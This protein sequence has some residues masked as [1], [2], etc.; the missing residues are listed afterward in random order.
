MADPSTTRELTL[1]ILSALVL[2][3]LAVGIAYI[4]G[5]LF[6]LFWAA[7]ALGVFWEWASLVAREDRRAV[8]MTGGAAIVLASGLAGSGRIMGSV[9]V[10]AMGALA[11]AGLAG[12][13]ERFW[14][15]AGLPYAGAIGIAPIVLRSESEFG[16]IAIILLFAVVWATDIAAYVFGRLIGGP[17]LMPR[18]SPH[19]TWSGAIA[20]TLTAVAAAL[21]VAKAAA[22]PEFFAIGAVAIILSVFAQAG[23]LFESGI[24]RR[25][26]AKDSSRL[27]PGHGGL[28]DRLDG[29]VAAAVVAVVLGLL[30]GGADAPASGLVVW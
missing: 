10:L 4:G 24:K 16:F 28:M 17:K 7:A 2:A 11:V 23:D 12:R 3:P 5:W 26:G 27:I 29:F 18:I 6:V 22:L 1:R 14:A 9:I 20:G 19:K 21:A 25:F 15:A 13:G 8:L 30:R